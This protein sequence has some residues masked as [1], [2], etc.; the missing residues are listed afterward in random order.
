[1]PEGRDQSAGLGLEPTSA[2]SK[3]CSSSSWLRGRFPD[4]QPRL[5]RRKLKAHLL[6]LGALGL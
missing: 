1:M 3:A 5:Q 2:L 6:L 4:I